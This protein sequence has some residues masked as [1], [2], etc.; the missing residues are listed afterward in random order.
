MCSLGVVRWKCPPSPVCRGL[1]AVRNGPSATPGSDTRTERPC[2]PNAA[3]MRNLLPSRLDRRRQR[4]GNLARKQEQEAAHE[5]ESAAE[6]MGVRSVQE[7]SGPLSNKKRTGTTRSKKADI[8]TAHQHALAGGSAGAASVNPQARSMTQR[9]QRQCDGD[10]KAGGITQVARNG[11]TVQDRAAVAFEH[12]LSLEVE[13]LK[14]MFD[15]TVRPTRHVPN[16]IEKPVL[17]SQS[18]GR[19]WAERGAR[20]PL[21]KAWHELERQRKENTHGNCFAL[22]PSSSRFRRNHWPK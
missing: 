1:Q 6:G 10:A 20:I 15:A 13:P 3:I 11:S 22:S 17:L 7:T 2:Q 19:F 5:L 14:P 12:G 21:G 18:P 8:E 4:E 16:E 9:L